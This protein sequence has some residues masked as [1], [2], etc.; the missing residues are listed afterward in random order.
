MGEKE[1]R[2]SMVLNCNGLSC[3]LN[4]GT[5]INEEVEVTEKEFDCFDGLILDSG[6]EKYIVDVN[7]LRYET[8]EDYIYFNEIIQS[9]MHNPGTVTIIEILKK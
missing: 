4:F 6:N 5:E 2:K 3:N 8:F 1:Q 9:M 7:K